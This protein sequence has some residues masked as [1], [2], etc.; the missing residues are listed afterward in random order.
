VLPS[1]ADHA[2]S[3]ERARP[4][5]VADAP[6]RPRAPAA[7]GSNGGA[8]LAVRRGLLA[9]V[10]GIPGSIIRLGLAVG[11]SSLRLTGAVLNSV[12]SVVLPGGLMLRLRG[13]PSYQNGLCKPWHHA[14]AVRIRRAAIWMVDGSGSGLSAAILLRLLAKT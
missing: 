11:A 8:P 14:M 3:P 9:R 4:A 1:H 7:P 12:G 13:A 6:P 2:V 5:Y 10:A